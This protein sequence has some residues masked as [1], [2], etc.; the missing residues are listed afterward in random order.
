MMAHEWWIQ[1][2]KDNCKLVKAYVA[3]RKQA[4]DWDQCYKKCLAEEPKK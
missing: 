2:C 4:F 3:K 1:S